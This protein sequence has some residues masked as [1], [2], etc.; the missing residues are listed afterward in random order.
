MIAG[1]GGNIGVQIGPIGAILVNAGSEQMPDKVL[2]AVKRLTSLPIRYIIDTSADPDFVGGNAKLSKAGVTILAGAVGQSGVTEE[3]INNG[4]IASVLAH[5]N[6]LI[7]MSA[8]TGQVAPFPEEMWP[9]KTYAFVRGYSMYLN[10]EGIQVLHVPA[11]HID[12][13]SIV[14]FRRKDVIVTGDS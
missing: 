7:R 3:V 5:E 12:G 11:A 9:S 14:S 2:A 4:G 6:V 1:A 8:P 13:D 10:G